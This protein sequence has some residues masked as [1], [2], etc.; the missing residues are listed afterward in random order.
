MT[1]DWLQQRLSGS[2]GLIVEE[3]RLMAGLLFV[4]CWLVMCWFVKFVM[5]I[6]SLS[7]CDT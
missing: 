3:S 4:N 7:G 2:S 6:E 5:L 1:G